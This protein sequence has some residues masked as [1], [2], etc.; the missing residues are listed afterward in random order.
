M[1]CNFF[2]AVLFGIA[3]GHVVEVFDKG[4]IWNARLQSSEDFL[5]VLWFGLLAIG[6]GALCEE[7]KGIFVEFA[8]EVTFPGGPRSLCDGR[9]VGIS[10]YIEHTQDIGV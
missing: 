5:N 7:I 4:L 8:Q 3:R 6:L 9:Q 1:L 10:E 2:R